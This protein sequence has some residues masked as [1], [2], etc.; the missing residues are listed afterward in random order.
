MEFVHQFLENPRYKALFG[1]FI[2]VVVSTAVLSATDIRQG[3][4]ERIGCQ[5]GEVEL[6]SG[7]GRL[8]VDQYEAS[9]DTACAIATPERASDTNVNMASLAC[10]ATSRATALPWR[11]VSLTQAQ[12]LCARGGKRLPTNAEWYALASGL[13]ASEGC[14]IASGRIL[15]TGEGDCET[16]MGVHDAVGN[17]WEW[18]NAEV[19]GGVYQN[20]VLPESGYVSLVDVDGVV[21]LTASSADSVFGNDYA[22]LSAAGLMGMMRGGFYGSKS[23]AGIFSINAAVPPDF[24]GAGVGF[25]CVRDL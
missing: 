14:N 19:V 7:G 15:K 6:F 18:V 13:A 2:A 5:E 24:A 3:E 11:Y 16:P 1:V 21:A 23:D 22:S 10:Q 25:R 8:C 9:P 4:T 20:R 17:V 12:Q